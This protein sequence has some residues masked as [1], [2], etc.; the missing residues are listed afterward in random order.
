MEKVSGIYRIVCKANGDYYYGSA[1]NIWKRWSNHKSALRRN[2]HVN[3]RVQNNWN[4]YGDA[5]FRIELT[6]KVS[7]DLLL[8]IENKYLK[9]H[10][11]KPHCMNILSDAYSP[12][13]G[14]ERSK[15]IS[16]S[17]KKYWEKEE[18]RKAQ[19]ERI[20]AYYKFHPDEPKKQSDKIKSYFASAENR[21]AQSKRTTSYFASAENRKAQSERIKAYHKAHPEARKKH[22]DFMKKHNALRKEK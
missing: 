19:S 6:E 13:G 7:V 12:P 8:E 21:K 18:N 2:V 11:G 4:K 10:V 3:C 17:L 14:P 5:A 20:K 22:S 1:K 9:E 16:Q 15:L